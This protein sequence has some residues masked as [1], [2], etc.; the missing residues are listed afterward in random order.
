MTNHHSLRV[1][2]HNNTGDIEG[3]ETL[4]YSVQY[5]PYCVRAVTTCSGHVRT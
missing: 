5:S 3:E 4:L 1:G 2:R